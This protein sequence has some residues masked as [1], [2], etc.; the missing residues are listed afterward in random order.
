MIPWIS[1]NAD[2]PSTD[3]KDSIL[4]SQINC[5]S[6]IIFAFSCIWYQFLITLILHFVN[7]FYDRYFYG[8]SCFPQSLW[9]FHETN[10][11]HQSYNKGN[12]KKPLTAAKIPKYDEDSVY[13]YVLS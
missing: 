12:S 2:N 5:V 4:F 11:R 3:N 13:V 9:Y 6:I 7:T 8:L 10:Y 1:Y